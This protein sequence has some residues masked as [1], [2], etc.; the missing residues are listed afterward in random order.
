MNSPPSLNKKNSRALP[1][2]SRNLVHGRRVRVVGGPRKGQTGSI[3]DVT[4]CMYE[5]SIDNG[6]IGHVWKQNVVIEEEHAAAGGY[7]AM[8]EDELS[9]HYR[10]AKAIEKLKAATEEV[11]AAHSAL[12]QAIA[13]RQVN[14]PP[15]NSH[16]KRG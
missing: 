2:A 6:D 8:N 1:A 14:V 16:N 11:E 15:K 13:S 5:L 7:G 10:L 12:D 4:D 3:R 9:L